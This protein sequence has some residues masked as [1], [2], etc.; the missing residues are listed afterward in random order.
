MAAKALEEVRVL[1]L[2]HMVSAPY[3]TKLLADLGAEVI[4]IEEPWG[5]PTRRRGPFPE[6]LPH[7]ERSGL[8]LYLN[9][10]KLGVTLNL[11]TAAGRRIFQ[12]LI[13]EAQILVEDNPPGALEALGLGYQTLCQI[14]PGLILT[15][16]TPFGQTGPYRGYKAYD[17][18]TFHAGGEGYVLPG[19]ENWEEFMDRPPLKGAGFLGDYR[20]GLS[21]AVATLI[22]VI[23]QEATGEGQFLDVSKQE[24]LL[25]LSR[26]ETAKYPNEGFIESR[27]TRASP[28]GGIVQCK[29]GYVS[30]HWTEFHQWQALVEA[31]GNPPWAQE[32]RF[33]NHQSLREHHAEVNAYILEWTMGHTMDEIFHG[34]QQR[35]APVGPAYSAAELLRS[36][37]LKAR[38]FFAEIEHPEAGKVTYP[39]AP[40]HFS[41]TPWALGRPA[42]L[43]GQHNEE[44]YCQ[45]LGY[46]KEELVKLREAGAI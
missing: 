28:S 33:K 27:A 43:L 11:Q 37:Q 39:G 32:E 34:G 21:A 35:G 2:G 1:E 7:R 41:R 9:T 22:A 5:D 3:C 30:L 46:S 12:A 13:K 15:A 40:Y 4:K 8:F 23:H 42:P 16:I 20:C 31:M 10:N 44:V 14:N 45:R 26:F 25:N 17:L 19:G 38:G 18:N 24:A 36:E 29:D 6:D